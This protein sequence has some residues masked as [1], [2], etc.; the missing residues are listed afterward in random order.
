MEWT[1]EQR[2]VRALLRKR[3]A[4]GMGR[5]IARELGVVDDAVYY[6]KSGEKPFPTEKL[7]SLQ[8]ILMR[9]PPPSRPVPKRR[10]PPPGKAERRFRLHRSTVSRF[11]NGTLP[12]PLEQIEELEAYLRPLLARSAGEPGAAHPPVPELPPSARVTR[13]PR[14][15]HAARRAGGARGSAVRV[16]LVELATRF[17]EAL[18][19]AVQLEL[20]RGI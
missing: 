3:F 12:F 17:A 14:R 1:E 11:K 5:E 13:R 4:Y 15:E 2:A 8:Q 9:P 6:F 7:A 19:E 16:V 20:L 18:I 10:T